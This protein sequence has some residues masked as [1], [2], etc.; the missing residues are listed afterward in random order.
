MVLRTFLH[1][2]SKPQTLPF[3]LTVE[4]AVRLIRQLQ[5]STP[6]HP[7][8]LVVTRGPKPVILVDGLNIQKE[9]DVPKGI[10]VV[11]S[12]GCGDAMSGAFLASY[13]LNKDADSAVRSGIRAA[14]E[15]LQVAGCDPP[16][17]GGKC[18]I[19]EKSEA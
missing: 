12:V 6:A 8:I 9:F 3:L 13:A 16:L 17:H 15:I 10:P 11:D 2:Y 18:V 14:T 7:R 1:L 5:N 19:Q 4:E